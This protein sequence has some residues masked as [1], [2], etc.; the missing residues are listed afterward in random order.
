MG[1]KQEV[2]SMRPRISMAIHGCQQ[3]AVIAM[4]IHEQQW[5]VIAR[6]RL[7]EKPWLYSG[8]VREKLGICLDSLGFFNGCLMVF[9]VFFIISKWLI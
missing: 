7:Q 2:S 4:D 5:I 8:P 6:M 3:I 1:L 9:M